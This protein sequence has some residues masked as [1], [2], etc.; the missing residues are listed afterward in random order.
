MRVARLRGRW[1]QTESNNWGGDCDVYDDFQ[2]GDRGAAVD[3]SRGVFQR[4]GN[5]MPLAWW[6]EGEA[7]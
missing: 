7:S 4:I 1:C 6:L 5:G 2:T 3:S